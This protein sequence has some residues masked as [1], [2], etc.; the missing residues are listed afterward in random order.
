MISRGAMKVSVSVSIFASLAC[1]ASLSTFVL[2]SSYSHAEVSDS[3]LAS[4][5]VPDVCTLEGS[6][7]GTAHTAQVSVGSYTPNIGETT[8]KVTCNDSNGYSLYAVGYSNDT[9]GNTNLIG[10][11]GNI[12]TGTAND[13]S[14]SNWAMKLTAVSGS[15]TPTILNGYDNYHIVPDTATKVATRTGS[16]DV[17][18]T[19]EIKTTYAVS[20]SPS[21]AKGDYEGKVKYTVVH[22]N[23]SNADGTLESYPVTLNFSANTS[24]IVI[25]GVTYTSTSATP[26]L[27][28]GTHT[29]S[30]TYPSGYE[31]DSWSVTGN[32]TI[33]DSTSAST[34]INVTGAGTLTLAGFKSKL[35]MW[36]ATSADCGETMYDNRDGIERAYTTTKIGNLCWMTKNLMLGT[37]NTV[38]LYKATTNITADTYTLSASSTTGFSTYTAQNIY[39]AGDID[40]SSSQSCYGYYTFAAATAGTNPTSGEATSDIC[41]ANWRLPTRAECLSLVSSYTTGATLTGS[42]FLGIYNGNYHDS[43]FYQGGTHGNY[44]SS[45]AENNISAYG[46]YFY[47]TSAGVYST[48]R[49]SGDGIRCV[50]KS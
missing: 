45:T 40:C 29:I 17:S 47:N 2:S 1:L 42:P 28:Y 36:N 14:V 22:P 43:A 7:V 13:G 26:S 4:V 41:P 48:L 44:W 9:V 23:Y 3:A 50:A 30:G 6:V 12:V 24:S 18:S 38:T 10:T 34:T 35:Y 16:I 19:S 27:T 8:I 33:S 37:S 25:D 5:T 11:N 32:I 20:I 31:F 46:L 39:N 21:Q 15:F 49:Y